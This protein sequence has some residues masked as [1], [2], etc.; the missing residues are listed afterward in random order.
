MVITSVHVMDGSSQVQA[1]YQKYRDFIR[2]KKLKYRGLVKLN[3]EFIVFMRENDKYTSLRY[4]PRDAT[5]MSTII[6]L[7]FI[8][9]SL[10]M[11]GKYFLC[12]WY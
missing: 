12:L 9:N 6:Y 3:Q 5:K 1:S 10:T 7:E 8:I 4:L 11:N 2:A